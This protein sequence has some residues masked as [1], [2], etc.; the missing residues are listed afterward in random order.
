MNEQKKK[1]L[2]HLISALRWSWD[3]LC[4]AFRDEAAFRQELVLFMILTPLAIWIAENP[5]E[6]ILLIGSLFLILIVELLNTAMEETVNR[7]GSEWHALS[8]KAKDVGSAAVMLTIIH[9]LFVWALILY[10]H[11]NR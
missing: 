4:A 8:K 11:T 5:I 1:G 2:S 7:I 9:A 10:Q 3:G 6:V